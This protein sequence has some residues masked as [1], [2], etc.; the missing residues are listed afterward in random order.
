MLG[1]LQL[2]FAMEPRPQ[3]ACL[4]PRT[5]EAKRKSL[6]ITA[7]CNYRGVCPVSTSAANEN[8]DAS[9]HPRG[10]K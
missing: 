6:R 9:T 10:M 3:K 5:V 1:L 8:Y 4:S 7:L 2:P